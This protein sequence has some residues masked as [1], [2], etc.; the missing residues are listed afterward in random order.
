MHLLDWL[1]PWE[2]SPL[3]L[4]FFMGGA[5]LFVRGTRVHRVTAWRQALFWSG[6]LILYLSMHTRLDYYVVGTLFIHRLQHEV[7]HRLWSLL[8]MG[9]YPRQVLRAGLP[10]RSRV[11][12]RDYRR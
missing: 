5:W 11:R 10:K 6:M 2:F 12:L 9:A 1:I 4:F 3:F 8:I 7:L